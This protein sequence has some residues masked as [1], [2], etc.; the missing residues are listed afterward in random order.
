MEY[1]H[2]LRYIGESLN[3]SIPA[4]KE[5]VTKH[6]EEKI[7]TLAV[8]QEECGAHMLDLNAAVA[9]QDEIEDL[10]WMVNTVQSVTKLPLVLDSSNPQ[11]LQAAFKVYNGPPPIISSITGEWGEGHEDLLSLAVEHEC[12]L[13]AM[14][15]DKS[16]ISPDPQKRFEIATA[17]CERTTKAGLKPENLYLD[18]L[19][20]TISADT[21]AGIAFLNLMSLLDEHL[22]QVRKFCGASNVS[23]GMPLRKLINHTFIP[24]IVALGMDAFLVNVRDQGLMAIFKACATLIGQDEWSMQYISAFR[25]GKLD[26]KK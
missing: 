5:A 14:C 16:G 11:A 20:M 1:Q 12:G 10:A 13:V 15:M 22:P 26:V 7:K 8:R 9:G 25:E 2:K 18:P 19:V 17:L 4:I 21:K 24:M 3:A 6:D 23:Y